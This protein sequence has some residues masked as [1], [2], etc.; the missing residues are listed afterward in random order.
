VAQRA[1][2]SLESGERIGTWVPPDGP[3][4]Y[5]PAV[6]VRIPAQSRLVLEMS[7]R[8]SAERQTDRSSV[9]LYFAKSP[10]RPLGYRQLACGATP[11]EAAIEVLAVEA[12][13]DAAGE[14]IEVAAIRPDGSVEPLCLVPRF[15]PGHRPTFRL[16][17]AVALPAGSVL[18]VRS[19]SPACSAGIEFAAAQ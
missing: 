17:N 3:V 9:A 1:T 5:P 19:S 8:K 2:L 10:L 4:R 11:V 12:S 13:A 14:S 6:G 16:R 15:Q 18:E 7:Y